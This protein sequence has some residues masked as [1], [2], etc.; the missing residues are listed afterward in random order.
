M[1]T[2]RPGFPKFHGS[3][4]SFSLALNTNRE[5][6]IESRLLVYSQ[7]SRAVVIEF[8]WLKYLWDELSKLEMTLFILLPEVHH[9]PLKYSTLR[10]VLLIGKKR[11]RDRIITAPFLSEREKP[12]RKFYQGYK[13]L[14]VEIYEFSRSLPRV[15]KFSGWIKSSSAKDKGSLG[16]PKLLEPLAITENDYED[17]IFDWYNFLTV[18][19]Y[20]S[21]P[22]KRVRH[23]EENQIVRNSPILFSRS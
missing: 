10:S 9:S 18:D 13:R 20:F 4:K 1:V 12:L 8:L 5:T 11:T 22:R 21:E 3:F 6:G 19:D 14:D 2:A 15:P 17:E 7:G 16:G 23:P